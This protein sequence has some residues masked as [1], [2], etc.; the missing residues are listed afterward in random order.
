VVARD[1]VQVIPVHATEISSV[2]AKRLFTFIDRRAAEVTADAYMEMYRRNSELLP[3][4]A[5]SESFRA[6]IVATYPFHPT[7]VDFL[8]NKLAVAENFQGT[9]GVLRVLALAVRSLWQQKQ[10]VPMIHA[11]HLD[12]RSDRVVNEIL[13]RTNS[14]DLLFVLNADIGSVD[15]GG[16]E[17][18]RSNAE[19]ADERN[20][21]PEGYP[22]YEYTWKTVFLHSLVGRSEGVKSNVFGV[23][24]ADAIFATAFPGLTPPQVR[25]ALE[26]IQE[27]AFYLRFDHGKYYASEEP[28]INSVLAHIRRTVQAEEV[29]ELLRVTARKVLSQESAAGFH[30]EYD[31]S[32][33]EHIPDNKGRPTIGV[34]SLYADDLDVEQLITMAGPNRPRQQ[35]NLVILLVPETVSVKHEAEQLHLLREHPS[36]TLEA[37]QELERLA[38][39][40]RAFRLLKS[41]PQRY[42]VNPARLETPEFA[43]R[44]SERE[45]ALVTA[46]SQAYTR[47]YYPSAQ[48]IIARQ[49]LRTAGGEG[50]TPFFE[51][52]RRTLI[53]EGELLTSQHTTTADLMNLQQLLFRHRDVVRIQEVLSNFLCLRTWPMLESVTVLEQIVRAGVQKGTWC[54]F[55]MAE[56]GGN[57]PAEFYDQK[58]EIP[59]S[60]NLLRGDYSLITVQ[61]AKQRGWTEPAQPAIDVRRA[62]QEVMDKKG[63]ARVAEVTA[64]IQEQY[65]GVEAYEVQKAVQDLVREASL[66]SYHGDV[67]PTQKPELVGGKSAVTYVP[68][69]EDVL[70]TRAE[71]EVRGWLTETETRGLSLSGDEAVARLRPLVNRLSS[72]Y[73]RGARTG[74][75]TLD[76]T[77]IVLPDG[78][79][80]RVVLSDV[81]PESMRALSELFEVLATILQHAELRDAYVVIRDVNEEC[82]VVRELTT[83][84]NVRNNHVG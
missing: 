27:S 40:V 82:P 32:A 38:R 63:L 9:R 36:K 68:D 64:A 30:V 51:L 43:Q 48:G 62:V 5:T 59:M 69:I 53:D 72:L 81:T 21:H 34:V 56:D 67:E 10:A 1:A 17:G 23:T 75:D 65:E 60:V 46:V 20:P 45:H 16:L 74:F 83:P 66:Y 79:S 11:C 52:I 80:L 47:F 70:L 41:N 7:L 8:N 19:A 14:S 61:G 78:G 84:Q 2:L 13:G 50:G 25:K 76:L 6:R 73:S 77:E 44:Q 54:V 28:T 3:D 58:N 71:A 49:D 42:G 31:V 22:M 39:Q 29:R 26:E 55:R 35:Q 18:G 37:R 57:K 12:L 33:P 4:V 15:T 24:E